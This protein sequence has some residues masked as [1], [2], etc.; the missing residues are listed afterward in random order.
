M[1]GER[2]VAPYLHRHLRPPTQYLIGS[3]LVIEINEETAPRMRCVRL[4]R[5]ARRLMASGVISGRV[6]EVWYEVQKDGLVTRIDESGESKRVPEGHAEWRW[7]RDVQTWLWRH[8]YEGPKAAG[9]PPG[10]L[11]TWQIG[12]PQRLRNEEE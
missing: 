7:V 11:V 6:E 10:D 9:A 2:Q 1:N 4:K 12:A 5:R 8:T 3:R